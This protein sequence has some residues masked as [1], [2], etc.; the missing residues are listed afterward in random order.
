MQWWE[1]TGK[2]KFSG[3]GEKGVKVPVEGMDDNEFLRIKDGV[4]HMSDSEIRSLF[5]PVVDNIVNLVNNQ[6]DK[7]DCELNAVILVGGFGE[8]QFLYNSLCDRVGIPR[9]IDILRVPDAWTA[10]ASGALL[11][12][13]IDP[14]PFHSPTSDRVARENYGVKVTIPFTRGNLKHDENKGWVPS[15]DL[16]LT[17]F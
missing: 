4:I 5:D 13:L 10:V 1:R 3:V 9:I 6:I 17:E 15:V 11:N 14:L 8:N 12:G 16:F 7:T 2:R